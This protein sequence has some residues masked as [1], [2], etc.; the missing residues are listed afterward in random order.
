M[1]CRLATFFLGVALAAQSPLEPPNG[2]RLP[3]IFGSIEATHEEL[4]VAIREYPD[5]S[6]LRQALL[7]ALSGCL[8]SN[9]QDFRMRPVLSALGELRE[10]RALTSLWEIVGDDDRFVRSKPVEGD[11][12]AAAQTHDAAAQHSFDGQL[13][14]REHNQGLGYLQRR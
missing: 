9:C 11:R 10:R 4:L 14:P 13:S 5:Q 8:K 12:G 7:S 3:R 6:A 2:L 1:V